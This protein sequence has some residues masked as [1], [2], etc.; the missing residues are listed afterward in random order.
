MTSIRTRWALACAVGFLV[1]GCGDGAPAEGAAPAKPPS[2]P[3]IPVSPLPPEM[4]AAVASTRN[5]HVVSVHF[6]LKGTPTLGKP[7]PVD[8]AI[9]PH[10]P[11]LALTVHFEA[12]D[13]IALATGNV[14]ERLAE[15]RPETA[16]KH[17]LILL[18][19]KEGVFM[20]AAIVETETTDGS[21]SRVFSIPVIVGAPG[22]T[23]TT[24][25]DGPSAP[26]PP[27]AAS[28]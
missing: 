16:I 8:I 13:G 9:V 7:L 18:P 28:G 2:A 19:D 14:L 12:R 15:P 5:N 4:V 23:A 26:P 20:V 17:Q 25:A 3:T 6:A 1:A 27:P 24:P 21:V 11:V 10:V 22:A